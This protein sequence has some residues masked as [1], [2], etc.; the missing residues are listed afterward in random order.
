M[1]CA[2]DGLSKGMD[3]SEGTDLV[4]S[5]LQKISFQYV[6]THCMCILASVVAL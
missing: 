1:G 2:H 4:M 5:N 3:Y 6:C